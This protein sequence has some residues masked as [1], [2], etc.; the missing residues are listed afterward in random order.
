M[1]LF[2][3]GKH[4]L[5]KFNFTNFEYNPIILVSVN[6]RVRLPI[7]LDENSDS[8][9]AFHRKLSSNKQVPFQ[10]STHQYVPKILQVVLDE[11]KG[12]ST[13]A[14]NI[15]ATSVRTSTICDRCGCG[16]IEEVKLDIIYFFIFRQTAFF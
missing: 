16:N 7:T 4:I 9:W 1:W 3:Q 6:F 12:Y 15:F 2:Q 14:S 13:I 5:R 8:L 10:L 11:L